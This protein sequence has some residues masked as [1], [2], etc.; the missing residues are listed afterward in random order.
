MINLTSTKKYK[1][2]PPIPS[3]GLPDFTVLTGVNGSGK[4]QLLSGINEGYIEVKDS[5]SKNINYIKNTDFIVNDSSEHN[6]TSLNSLKEQFWNHYNQ[7]IYHLFDPVR[8]GRVYLDEEASKKVHSIA[9][10][11]GRPVNQLNEQ[12]FKLDSALLADYEAYRLTLKTLLYNDY[13]PQ[14]RFFQTLFEDEQV[15]FHEINRSILVDYL[16]KDYIM[17]GIL[18]TQIS[19]TIFNYAYLYAKNEYSAYLNKEKSQTNKV[20]SKDDFEKKYG[21]KPWELI[22]DTL[23]DL[24]AIS[25]SLDFDINKFNAMQDTF[26]LEFVK[27]DNGKIVARHIPVSELSSGEKTLLALICSFYNSKISKDFPDI[28]LLDEIDA[29]LHP[30]MVESFLKLI[31]EK[32]VNERGAKIILITHSPT[33]VAIAPEESIYT[34]NSSREGELVAKASKANALNLLTNGFVGI[35]EEASITELKFNVNDSPHDLIYAEGIT[36]QVYLNEA[37]RRMGS[38]IFERYTLLYAQGSGGLD[39]IWKL[40][41][42]LPAGSGLTHGKKIILLYDGDQVRKQERYDGN[43]IL[44]MKF[45]EGNPIKTGIE[46]L[47]PEA[48]IKRLKKVEPDFIYETPTGVLAVDEA[49]KSDIAN[50]VI[51]NATDQEFEDIIQVV[52]ELET[53]LAT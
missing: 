32:I 1:S 4:S 26:R 49:R 2:I 11:T 14:Y 31:R 52:K 45:V 19:A 41:N 40:I 8:G 28:L 20:L 27:K 36:D 9:R 44:C 46:N 30:S 23:N 17:G 42:H 33:T 13:N 37:A 34:M 3:M 43:R 35:T 48:L 53:Q 21:P 24:G 47:L 10:E 22:N 16:T 25:V 6:L 12:D 7:N 51:G 38:D 5:D 50:W 18:P 15:L 39:N 29:S